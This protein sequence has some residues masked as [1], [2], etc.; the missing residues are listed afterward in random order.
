MVI[1]SGGYMGPP[2]GFGG[3]RDR[4]FFCGGIRDKPKIIGGMRDW[5]ML[6]P[7]LAIS[8]I[9]ILKFSPNTVDSFKSIS[10]HFRDTNFKIFSNYSRQFFNQFLSI[11]DIHFKNF[12]NH[13]R[14]FKC[15]SSYFRDTNFKNFSNHV[16]QCL[17]HF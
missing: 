16:G 6:N 9:Q 15:I 3:M 14:Q 2:P 10:S 4:A 11:S 13:G 8:E 1:C 12:S 7:F 5:K 17:M